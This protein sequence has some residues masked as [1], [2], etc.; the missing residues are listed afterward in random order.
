MS[1]HNDS[2][3]LNFSTHGTNGRSPPNFQRLQGSLFSNRSSPLS[4]FAYFYLI[5]AFLGRMGFKS[6][7]SFS[8]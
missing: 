2:H 5:L 4:F 1:N 8:S 6:F 7:Y 3:I